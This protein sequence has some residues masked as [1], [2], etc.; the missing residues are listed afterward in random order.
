MLSGVSLT[1]PASNPMCNGFAFL[2]SLA[3][4][5]EMCQAL[6]LVDLDKVILTP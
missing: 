2:S 5:A 3:E 4:G 6:G 1:P